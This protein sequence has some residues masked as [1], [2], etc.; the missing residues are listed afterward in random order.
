MTTLYLQN[1][2]KKYGGR[3]VVNSVSLDV[4]SGDVVGLLGPNGAGKTTTFYMTVGMVKPDAGNVLLPQILHLF[5]W[6]NRLPE[7]TPWRSTILKI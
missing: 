7:L 2:I 1:L 5:S 4:K 6:T 3:Q